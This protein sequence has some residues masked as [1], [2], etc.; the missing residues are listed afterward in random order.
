[1]W[2]VDLIFAI[3]LI[4]SAV[5]GYQIGFIGVILD[6]IGLGVALVL[7]SFGYRPVSTLLS[8]HLQVVPPI[9]D[10]VSFLLLWLVIDL[11]YFAIVR[12]F[13]HTIPPN[14]RH[15]RF[16][17]AGGVAANTAKALI[18]LTVF[19]TIVAA[20]P[21]PVRYKNAITDA[22]IPKLL[23]DSTSNLQSYV[24][25]ALGSRIQDTLNFLTIRPKSGESVPL[26][27]TTTNVRPDPETEAKMLE[28]VNRE[29]VANGLGRLGV[30][31]GAKLVG[32]A[33]CTDM[34][35]RGYF[36]HETPEGV[37]PF[38]RMDAAGVQYQVAGENLALAPTLQLAHNG[39]MNSPGHRANILSPDFRRVGI[40][41]IDGGIYGLMFCQEF[42][43]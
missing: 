35:A 30:N 43:D 15:A 33:H 34:F 27:F 28:L 21:L 16:N 22:K 42:T 5:L 10:V 8:D 39:L 37:D 40:G 36:A 29:R 12:R 41:V 14:L 32:R 23:L 31:E 9:A 24:N 4:Y 1:M 6:V 18:L 2:W 11:I 7:A 17:R 3:L 38:Q 19:L 26:R 13:W 25:R 20:M